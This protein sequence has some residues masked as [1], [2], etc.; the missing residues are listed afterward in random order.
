[1]T[2]PHS[3]FRRQVKF[4]VLDYVFKVLGRLEDDSGR[5]ME[6]RRLVAEERDLGADGMLVAPL[7]RDIVDAMLPLVW[8]RD[9]AMSNDGQGDVMPSGTKDGATPQASA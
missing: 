2:S 1:M 4:A 9:I 5:I 3:Q 6:A 7:T 8:H